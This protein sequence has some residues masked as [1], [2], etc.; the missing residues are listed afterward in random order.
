MQ[1]IYNL[2]EIVTVVYDPTSDKIYFGGPDL[3]SIYVGAADGSGMSSLISFDSYSQVRDIAIDP[4]GGWIY[5][6]DQLN[7]WKAPIDG[8]GTPSIMFSKWYPRIWSYLRAV[9][10]DLATGTLFLG[11]HHTPAPNYDTIWTVNADGT[12]TILYAGDFGGIRG[13][14]LGEESVITAKANIDVKPG[15]EPNCFNINGQGVIPVAILGS[16]DF[17]VSDI[18]LPPCH[19]SGFLSASGG[20]KTHCAQQRIQMVMDTPIWFANLKMIL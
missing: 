15:S 18:N 10:I 7:L 11:E 3:D 17:N 2:E 20:T 5:W 9:E 19:L 1:T 12:R 6:V 4:A 16:A 14:T 13:I 8:T